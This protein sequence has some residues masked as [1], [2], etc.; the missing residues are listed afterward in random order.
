M[1]RGHRNVEI[2]L[3]GRNPIHRPAFAPE[4]A[5]DNPDLGTAVVNHFGSIA[6]FHILIARSGHLQAPGRIGPEL[7][8]CIW[9]CAVA[10]PT[11]LYIAKAIASKDLRINSFWMLRFVCCREA[12]FA[13]LG[14]E[15]FQIEQLHGVGSANL[16]AIQLAN[17]CCIKPVCGVINVLKRPVSGEHNAVRPDL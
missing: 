5:D 2:K 7:E 4:L 17:R 6:G 11:V 8:P 14:Y 9:P 12:C 15:L 16:F 10:A 3:I 13:N 1:H